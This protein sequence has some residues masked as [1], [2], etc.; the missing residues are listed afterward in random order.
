MVTSRLIDGSAPPFIVLALNVAV[1]Y[2]IVPLAS[3]YRDHMRL[4]ISRL[5]VL[6]SIG[7]PAV[8][9]MVCDLLL[10]ASPA[11]VDGSRPVSV[12][13][14]WLVYLCLWPIPVFAAI[15]VWNVVQ[16]AWEKS[17]QDEVLEL[18]E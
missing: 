5:F 11:G 15:A 3:F 17:H 14:D 8:L 13:L 7:L 1:I 4:S 18:P 6:I 9:G 16:H 12:C 2:G 10:I